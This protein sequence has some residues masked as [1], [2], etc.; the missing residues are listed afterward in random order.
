MQQEEGPQLYFLVKMTSDDTEI[1]AYMTVI[2]SG[3]VNWNTADKD[4]GYIRTQ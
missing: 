4:S 1:L 2:K 3:C